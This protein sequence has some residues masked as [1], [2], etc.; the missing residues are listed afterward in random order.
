[1]AHQDLI[2]ISNTEVDIA[3]SCNR[4]VQAVTDDNPLLYFLNQSMMDFAKDDKGNIAVIPQYFFSAEN[5]EKYNKK[6]QD[7][8][9]RLIYDL[10]LTEGSDADKVRKVHDWMCTNVE[11]DY[12]GSD[13]KD[14]SRYISAHNIIG[15]F[16]HRKAQCEGIA[17]A[18]KVL[19]NAVDVRCIFATGKAKENDGSMAE[20]GWNIVNIDGVPYQLDITMDIGAGTDGFISYDYFNVTD[21]QIR[22]NHVFST[23]YPKCTAKEE[24]YFEKSG[25][26]FSSKKKLKE[27]I[28]KQ[29]KIGEMMIYF[30]L[31][32]KLKA[33]EIYEEMI[34]DGYQI[35]CDMGK[36]NA[37]GYRAVN[38]D[39]NT[40][41]IMYR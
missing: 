8:A 39:M 40:C 2:P 14:L 20:H 25:T 22:K 36:E 31:A 38:E 3:K 7:S 12:G 24:N 27:Y 35:L 4:I 6:I 5:A 11:Y 33:A 15:V 1:M 9:N 30:R 28:E 34:N 26:V 19:L 21:A 32:G 13:Q 37:K 29:V 41:R 16:A 10:K 18:A 17:K 23:G